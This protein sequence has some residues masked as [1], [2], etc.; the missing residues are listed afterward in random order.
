VTL[1]DIFEYR[2]DKDAGGGAGQLVYSGLRP[3]CIKFERNGAPLPAYM[4]QHSFG[5]DRS[6]ASQPAGVTPVDFGIR[7]GRVERRFGR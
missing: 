5:G 2:F 1:Q 6:A 3:S 4:D 7:P